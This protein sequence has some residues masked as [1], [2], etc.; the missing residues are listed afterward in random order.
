MP[1]LN[2]DI[3]FFRAFVKR[4]YYTHNKE[5]D[6]TFDEVCAFGV[7]CVTNRIV[8]FH[9]MTDF[10]MNR[11]RVPLSALYWKIPEKDI[12]PHFKQLWD[13]FGEDFSVTQFSYL[14]GKRC[15]VTLK[16]KIEVW[17]TYLFTIDWFNNSFSESSVDAKSC[18]ILLADAGY[19]LGQPNNRIVWRDMNFITREFPVPKKDIKVDKEFLRV[20]TFSD[21]WISEDGNS[22]YYDIN[23]Q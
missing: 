15:I 13:S 1:I 23:Q 22:F 11:A 4:S 18:H 5:H 9:V 2:S 10:G 14:N 21:K 16:D 20:E 6:N 17:A 19:F 8:T 7:Q 12:E 3:P